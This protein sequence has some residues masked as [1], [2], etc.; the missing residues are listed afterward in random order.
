MTYVVP[1]ELKHML[2]AVVDYA[3]DGPV[4]QALAQILERHA[5]IVRDQVLRELELAPSSQVEQ[6]LDNARRRLEL[7]RQALIADGYFTADEV[8]DDIA[9]RIG[10]LA[11][12]LRAK[13]D[14]T[15]PA[16]I[17]EA[18]NQLRTQVRAR[19]WPSPHPAQLPG[20]DG[21]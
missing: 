9:P 17:L 16:P 5:E 10:E 8:G 14:E 1:V 2:G 18:L 6:E 4:D 19:E 13:L 21:D 15:M 12:H 20:G 11:S 3:G 7:A